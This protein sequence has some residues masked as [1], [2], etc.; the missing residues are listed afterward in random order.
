MS[1][2]I[3]YFRD[4]FTVRIVHFLSKTEYHEIFITSVTAFWRIRTFQK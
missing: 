4:T 2:L 1:F 3:L